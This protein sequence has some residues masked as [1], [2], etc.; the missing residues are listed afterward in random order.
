VQHPHERREVGDGPRRLLVDA[1]GPLA[2]VRPVGRRD[3]QGLGLEAER[4]EAAARS[5]RREDSERA[6]SS[7]FSTATTVRSARRCR[8]TASRTSPSAIAAAR[9][10]P[11]VARTCGR[12]SGTYAPD[13]VVCDA[14]M[15]RSVDVPA[16]VERTSRQVET[17]TA[18]VTSATLSRGRAR[19]PCA[20]AEDRATSGA[21]GEIGRAIARADVSATV[22]NG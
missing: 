7:S 9:A 13:S 5:A 1:L 18:A 16:V 3:G 17:A 11:A 12:A 2:Q 10:I 4:G 20:I 21:A 8:R 19:R 15:V 22:P 14:K 6:S